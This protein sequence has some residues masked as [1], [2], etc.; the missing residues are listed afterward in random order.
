MHPAAVE[1]VLPLKPVERV[2]V[3]LRYFE[4][5]RRGRRL[6]VVEGRACL[7][8]VR[9]RVR[10]RV[11]VRVRIRVRVMVRVR[12]RVRNGAHA[13]PVL[14]PKSETLRHACSAQ[15]TASS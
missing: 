6:E 15:T 14:S 4:A 3:L 1:G 12:V 2:V 13:S 9:A 5:A 11:R 10:V 8:R 7:P